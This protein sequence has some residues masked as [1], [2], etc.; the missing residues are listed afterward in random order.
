M[1]KLFNENNILMRALSFL[2]DMICLNFFFLLSCLPIVT[3]GTAISALYHV[4]VRMVRKEDMYIGSSYFKA[5]REC[6]KQSTLLFLPVCFAALFFTA[7]LYIIHNIIDPSYVI[8]QY[9]IWFIL[10]ALVSVMIYAFPLIGLYENTTKQVL[11]NSILLS[12]SNIPTTIFMIVIYFLLYLF[13]SRSGENLVI[14]FS[15][16]LF[17]GFAAVATFFSLFLSRILERCETN[18]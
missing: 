14:A 5:F 18:T 13:C 2:W 8:L 16:F 3:I 7:D 9:P 10:F 1:K 17:V 15:F 12:L 4:A 11:K 6:F